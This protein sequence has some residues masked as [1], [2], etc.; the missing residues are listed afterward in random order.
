MYTVAIFILKKLPSFILKKKE[1]NVVNIYLFLLEH[2]ISI[3]FLNISCITCLLSMTVFNALMI[4]FPSTFFFF[5]F[6]LFKFIYLSF[7]FYS[8][9]ILA[10]PH[11]LWDLSSLT[12]DGTKTLPVK[13]QS[14]ALDHQGIP[15]GL[16][17]LDFEGC[18]FF[19]SNPFH[20]LTPLRSCLHKF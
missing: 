4:T 9:F 17:V 2:S 6:L 3:K 18:F 8:I 12:R 16:R 7:F 19:F 20:M 13:V 14:P 15:V 5:F 10:I 11:S 1:K